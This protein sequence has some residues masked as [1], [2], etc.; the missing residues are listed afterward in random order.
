MILTSYI[1]KTETEI[2]RQ[3]KNNVTFTFIWK[4]IR[5]CPVFH[6]Y[7]N[8]ILEKENLWRCCTYNNFIVSILRKKKFNLVHVCLKTTNYEK[9]KSSE[10]IIQHEYY[11]NDFLR[12]TLVTEEN[13]LG[14]VI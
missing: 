4:D 5:K 3:T 2:K 10:L 6:M 9:K 1:Q 8:E 11:Q 14:K 7:I 12:K 13:M